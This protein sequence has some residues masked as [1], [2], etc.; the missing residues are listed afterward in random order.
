[1]KRFL[2]SLFGGSP[3]QRNTDQAELR[4]LQATADCTHGQL[5]AQGKAPGGQESTDSWVAARESG[6]VNCLL[7]VLAEGTKD[8]IAINQGEG[9]PDLKHLA[10]G[11]SDLELWA[12]QLAFP[13]KDLSTDKVLGILAGS[14]ELGKAPRGKLKAIMVKNDGSDL[15]V[16]FYA[17]IAGRG[18][19]VSV[20]RPEGK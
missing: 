11:N 19:N 13:Y 15:A 6:Y 1:M 9:L 5:V 14:F 18:L 20:V 3:R 12:S 10:S 4:Q 16:I 17:E 7:T 8:S 2:S